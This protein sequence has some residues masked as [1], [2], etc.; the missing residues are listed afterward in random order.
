MTTSIAPATTHLSARIDVPPAAQLAHVITD[1]HI[2]LPVYLENRSDYPA[3]FPFLCVMDL[4]LN[5]QPEANWV[6]SRIASDGRKL[7][8]CSYS[9]AIT[10]LPGDQLRA[11]TLVMNVTTNQGLRVTFNGASPVPLETLRDL[12]LFTVAGAANFPAQRGSATVEADTLRRLLLLS[13][14]NGHGQDR[15]TG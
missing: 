4:G 15:M 2:G 3:Q 12:R 11:M 5:L 1:G 6:L 7:L 9:S 10:L 8:R 13:L 14:A